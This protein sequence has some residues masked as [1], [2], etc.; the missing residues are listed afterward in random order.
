MFLGGQNTLMQE[1]TISAI[2]DLIDY[3]Q[4][5]IPM[6]NKKEHFAVDHI[7]SQLEHI[8]ASLKQEY[9]QI[10]QQDSI[11]KTIF[12]D[13]LNQPGGIVYELRKAMRAKGRTLEYNISMTAYLVQAEINFKNWIKK[14]LI[15]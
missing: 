11:E 12:L 2:N 10:K 4:K 5:L 9:E 1:T 6:T 15:S 14:L 3:I 8:K 7:S 13:A